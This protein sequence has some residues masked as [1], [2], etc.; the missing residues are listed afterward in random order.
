MYIPYG[1]FIEHWRLRNL[2]ESDARIRWFQFLGYYP[3][4]IDEWK[5]LQTEYGDLLKYDFTKWTPTGRV[6]M[7]SGRRCWKAIVF[8]EEK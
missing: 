1:L 7:V 2:S 8:G 4:K 3:T 6:P 5:L